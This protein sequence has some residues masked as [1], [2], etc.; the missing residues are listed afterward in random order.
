M[1]KRKPQKI[2]ECVQRLYYA[3]RQNELFLAGRIW[4]NI[5]RQPKFAITG[6]FFIEQRRTADTIRKRSPHRAHFFLVCVF[7]C[8]G[9]YGCIF[10]PV[11]GEQ[12]AAANASGVASE[13]PASPFVVPRGTLVVRT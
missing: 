9:V 7:V 4:E 11:S 3:R 1:R 10:W 2:E 5:S 12:E 8:V 6:P 13:P